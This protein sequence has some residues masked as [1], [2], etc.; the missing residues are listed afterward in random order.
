MLRFIRNFYKTVRPKSVCHSRS[1]KP[2]PARKNRS[3]TVKQ[4]RRR[5][6]ERRKGKST[7]KQSAKNVP[8]RKAIVRKIFSE[9]EGGE[10]EEEVQAYGS[11]DHR[12]RTDPAD[13]TSHA[14]RTG[15]ETRTRH[16]GYTPRTGHMVS[17]TARFANSRKDS[18]SFL[19]RRRIFH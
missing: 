8:H 11:A 10:G 6:P 2:E 19:P 7:K 1:K 16:T 4:R 5:Q 17:R 12:A 13:H 9:R 18:G 3:R 14:G 15:H